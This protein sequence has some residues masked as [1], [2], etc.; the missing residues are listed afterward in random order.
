MLNEKLE[1]RVLRTKVYVNDSNLKTEK[2][3]RDEE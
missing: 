3:V 1:I 2:H